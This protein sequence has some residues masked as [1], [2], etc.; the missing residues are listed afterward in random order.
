MPAGPIDDASAFPEPEATPAWRAHIGWIKPGPVSK[1]IDQFFGLTPPD[2]NVVIST[3]MWS[4]K[5]TNQREFD[6]ASI[7]DGQAQMVAMARELMTYEAMDFL[8]VTGDL[9][10]CALGP[11]W[12]ATMRAM[13]EEATGRPSAT[14]MTAA[15]DALRE[16]GASSVVV[17]APVG[18]G[19]L[20]AVRGYLEASGFAVAGTEGIDTRS[21]HDIRSLP[22]QAPYDLATAAFHAHP[23]ADAIYLPS[24]TWR[25]TEYASRLERELGVPVV[26][27]Y[28][29]L[30]WRALTAIHYP[31]RVAGRGSLLGR[32]G[33]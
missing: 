17:A 14:A 21:S 3:T 1:T 2:V 4:L 20:V 19:K 11:E 30:I 26:T 15:V 5:M 18:Q 8:A 25:A 12:N 32:V 28:N 6:P 24:L 13:V 7:Q 27:L 10:Q 31:A 29:S 16:V 22:V 23:G 33:D 9:V